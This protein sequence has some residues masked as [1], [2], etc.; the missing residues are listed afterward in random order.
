MHIIYLRE[1]LRGR[2]RARTSSALTRNGEREC[3]IRNYPESNLG[4]GSLKVPWLQRS[5]FKKPGIKQT[6]RN[7]VL[8]YTQVLAC[9]KTSPLFFVAKGKG[10]RRPP[11]EGFSA[12]SRLQMEAYIKHVF[13]YYGESLFQAFGQWSARQ[14]REREKH[15]APP[16]RCFFLLTSLCAIPTI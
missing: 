15:L 1:R 2:A 4:T 13:Y 16:P 8:M 9:V 11:H 6:L 7:Q 12:L 10:N 14:G 3:L 5:V